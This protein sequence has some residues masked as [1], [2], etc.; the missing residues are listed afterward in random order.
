[1]D[2]VYFLAPDFA[3]S[4]RESALLWRDLAILLTGNV[5]SLQMRNVQY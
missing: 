5:D 2:E 1:M 4:A 3:I